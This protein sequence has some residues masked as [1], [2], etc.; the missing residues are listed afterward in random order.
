MFHNAAEYRALYGNARPVPALYCAPRVTEGF[1]LA[2]IRDRIAVRAGLRAPT[3]ALP[4]RGNFEYIG[5]DFV[6]GWAQNPLNPDVPVCLDIFVA[7]IVVMQILANRYR[8]DLVAAGIGLGR[9]SFRAVLPEPLTVSEL[10]TVEVRRS[11]DGAL[12]PC[13]WAEVMRAA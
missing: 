8:S 3:P 5:A 10:Q 4:F 13:N 12:L 2:A 1:A 11:S 6:E 7:G 9:H